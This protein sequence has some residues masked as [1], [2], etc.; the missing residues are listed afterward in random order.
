[1]KEK[2]ILLRLSFFASNLHGYFTHN[3]ISAS[4]G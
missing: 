3:D 1:M 4:D 2:K